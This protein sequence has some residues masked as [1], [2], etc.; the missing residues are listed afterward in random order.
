MTLGVPEIRDYADGFHSRIAIQCKKHATTL[1]QVQ[2]QNKTMEY[3]VGA[4][5]V[6][7]PIQRMVKSGTVPCRFYTLYHSSHSGDRNCECHVHSLVIFT[8]T[9]SI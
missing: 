8:L 1:A 7:I 3:H 2:E 6:G 9:A 4:A 5:K